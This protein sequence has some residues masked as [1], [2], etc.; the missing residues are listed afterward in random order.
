MNQIFYTLGSVIIVSL[1]S[2]IGVVSLSLSKNTLNKL[3]LFLVSISAG[4]LFGNAFLHLLPK[5]VEKTG[6]SLQISFTLLA[7]ILVFFVLERGL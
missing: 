2:L 1:V 7:G 5:A 4:T 3:L 6:F